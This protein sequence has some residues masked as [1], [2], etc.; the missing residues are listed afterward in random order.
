MALT[1]LKKLPFAAYDFTNSVLKNVKEV[2][3][4]AEQEVKS[5]LNRG[6]NP[7]CLTIKRFSHIIIRNTQ[8]S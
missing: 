1:A 8:L 4:P 3:K 2:L 6:V 7:V 5:A